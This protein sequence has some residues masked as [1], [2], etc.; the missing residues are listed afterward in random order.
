MSRPQ[1]VA[2]GSGYH[3]TGRKGLALEVLKATVKDARKVIKEA[4]SPEEYARLDELSYQ[5]GLGK[6][7]TRERARLLSRRTHQLHLVL[8]RTQARNFIFG[9]SDAWVAIRSHWCAVAG[10]EPEWLQRKTR[11]RDEIDGVFSSF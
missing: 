10:V 7:E 9:E 2:D 3:V 8:D 1:K 5:V 11:E 6:T 4:L